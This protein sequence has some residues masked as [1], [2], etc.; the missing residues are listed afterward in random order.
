MPEQK[1]EFA[2]FVDQ[3]SYLVSS[4]EPGGTL[5]LEGEKLHQRLVRVL[6]L[7]SGDAVILF[8]RA[9]HVRFILQEH[10]GKTRMRGV[11]HTKKANIILHPSITFLLP[12]LKR[13]DCNAALYS[14]TEIG[15]NEVRLVTTQ[16]VRR[17][18]GGEGEFIRLRRVMVAA[19]EQSKNFAFPELYS[20]TS[21][22]IALQEIAG[23]CIYFDPSGKPLFEIV[24]SLVGQSPEYVTLMVG[25][26]GDL[27]APE[28]K[29]IKEAGF[30]FCALTPTILR[31]TQATAV[32]AG[33]VRSI[34]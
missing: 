15:V 22:S 33:I 17:A 19:A 24:S 7:R 8:D 20:P 23:I 13:D 21:L 1:H 29:I 32:G 4:V 10:Q 14:L 31:A 6:R 9:C 5:T 30:I 27:V 2:I 3:L 34:F 28:K 25:P 18:W 11:I 16:K 26:E 12:L